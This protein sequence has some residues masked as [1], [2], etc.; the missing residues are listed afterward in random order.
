MEFSAALLNAGLL[1]EDVVFGP[2]GEGFFRGI[3]LLL[4]LRAQRALLGL[5]S[6]RYVLSLIHI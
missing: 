4:L 5:S 1:I 2:S 3:Q 6:M